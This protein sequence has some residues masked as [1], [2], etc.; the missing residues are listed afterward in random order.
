MR[1]RVARE[2]AHPVGRGQVAI[3]AARDAVHGI[4]SRPVIW[5]IQS[6][7]FHGDA[8]VGPVPGKGVQADDH[9]PDPCDDVT[10]QIPR[11]GVVLG[12]DERPPRPARPAPPGVGP[13]AAEVDH[14]IRAALDLEVHFE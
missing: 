14:G 9:V 1:V 10:R 11:G 7:H 4:L 3:T 6:R 8:H 12:D 13:L 2:P 5:T